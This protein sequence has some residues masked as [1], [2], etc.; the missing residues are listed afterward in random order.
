[1]S[2]EDKDSKTELPTEKKIRDAM[3]KGN[4][5]FSREITIFASTL[6]IYLFLVFFMLASGDL[7]KRKLVK[8]AGDT[9][10]EKKMTIEVIDEIDR[11][12]RRYLGVMVVANILAS[13]LDALADDIAARVAPGGALALSGILD[14]Q[15][16]PLLA[17][18][19]A[20]FDDLQVAVDGDW[21]R[22]D[23]RRR[24]VE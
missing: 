11:Q 6:A 19:G 23:G 9:L 8:I 21:V 3:E 10:T 4:T 2:D 20:W 17:R 13:A 24:V 16:A 5:P 22:I 12:I 18:Y 1:M 14:G 15:Q 7:F